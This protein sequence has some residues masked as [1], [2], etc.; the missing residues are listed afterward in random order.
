MGI[1]LSTIVRFTQLCSKFP[2][3]LLL[4]FAC[5]LLALDRHISYITSPNVRRDIPIESKPSQAKFKSAVDGN[6]LQSLVN[7]SIVFDYILICLFMWPL[8][9]RLMIYIYIF[10]LLL[11]QA[12]ESL[13]KTAE[14]Y[15]YVKSIARGE[16]LVFVG[17]MAVLGYFFR[18]PK[19][20]SRMIH[21]VLQ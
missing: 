10:I 3:T 11:S 12:S 21:S 18:T 5:D 2:P 13:W 9:K 4:N 20:L 19:P 1:K 16:I 6:L 14:E 15:G 8:S 17:A 7:L